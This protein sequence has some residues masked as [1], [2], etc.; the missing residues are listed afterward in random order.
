MAPDEN[1]LPADEARA[2]KDE[3]N[4]KK[5]AKRLAE[6]RARPPLPK[7]AKGKPGQKGNKPGAGRPKGSVNKF[8]S[9][10]ADFLEV[11]KKLGGAEGL[12]L[13]AT[14]PLRPG[15]LARFYKMLAILLPKSVQLSVEEH[16]LQLA[17]QLKSH[18]PE[19]YEAVVQAMNEI[20]EKQ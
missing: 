7:P 20:E 5:R 17:E 1:K 6:R 4:A 11:H 15:N 12:H 9:L 19:L 13:W 16:A 10:K 2:K 18:S 8:T 14:D 3:R